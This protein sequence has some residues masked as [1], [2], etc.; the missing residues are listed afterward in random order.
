MRWLLR[1]YP[2]AWRERYGNELTHLVDETGLSLGAAVDVTRG[3][4]NE[5]AVVARDALHGGT[6]MVIGPAYRHPTWWALIGLAVFFGITY[7]F[8]RFLEK[9]GLYLRL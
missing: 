1:L 2:R 7:A 6:T 5:W 4:I 3:A 8:V 9:H